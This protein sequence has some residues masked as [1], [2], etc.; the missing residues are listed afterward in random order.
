VCG[1]AGIYNI[2]GRPVDAR[3]L[4]RMCDIL[5]HRGPDDEGRIFI[6]TKNNDAHAAAGVNGSSDLAFGHRRL[7]IIDLTAAGNQPMCNEDG[8]LWITYNGEIYN[9]RELRLVLEGRGHMFKSQSDTEVLLHAYE[10]YGT[11]S[12]RMLNGMFA[13]ALWDGRQKLML[14]VRDRLGIKPLYYYHDDK[15]LLFSSEI[16]AILLDDR[17]NRV[18]N[19]QALCDFVTF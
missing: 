17:I 10:E 16:K 5:A 6:S 13:F 9:F 8:A 11:E 15:K 14:L 19:N 18:L 2:D 7:A 12:F 1:I 4:K 3:L